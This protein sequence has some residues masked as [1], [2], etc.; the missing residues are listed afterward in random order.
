MNE[1]KPDLGDNSGG[2]LKLLGI[3]IVEAG[4]DRVVLAMEVGPDHLQPHGVTHGGVHCTLVETAASIGGHLWI[5]A[6]EPAGSVVGVANNTD[7]L[8]ASTGGR[9]VATATP[10]HRG[11]SQ[12]LWLVEITDVGGKLIARGQVRLHN[13]LR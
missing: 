8:R 6:T 3:A 11:R 13:Q 5:S 2:F 7:F 4:P 10:I 1:S 9:L 12:Q